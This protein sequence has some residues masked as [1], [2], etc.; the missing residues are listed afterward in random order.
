MADLSLTRKIA[1]LTYL[2]SNSPTLRELA[3]HFKTQP[4]RM[5]NELMGLFTTEYDVGGHYETP[6]DVD[7]PEDLDEEVFLIDN[8]TD[9]FPALTLAEIISLL[10]LID[11]MYGSV[12]SA[13]RSQLTRLR[14]RMS[15]AAAD[16]GFEDALWPAP[17]VNLETGVADDLVRAIDQRRLIAVDYIKMGDGLTVRTDRAIVAPVSVTTGFHPLLIAGKG[18]DLRTYRL[19]RIASVE[20]LDQTYTRA[21]EKD[22]RAQYLDRNEF[23]GHAVTL[24]VESR[25]RWVVETI[26]VQSVTERDGRLIIDL[27]ASSISWLRTLL[28]Q[29]GD[30]VVAVEP[31]SVQQAIAREAQQYLAGAGH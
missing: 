21:L 2:A 12:D 30:A 4:E 18:T 17:T 8:Q 26:P 5:R 16:A 23:A 1:I 29:I 13:T 6:V 27:T 28:I 3:K 19:D 14:E 9:V 31:P 20:V 11:D 22:I 25:A 7:I 10:A 15:A 24:I